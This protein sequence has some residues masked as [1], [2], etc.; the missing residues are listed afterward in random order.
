[1][2]LRIGSHRV[3][4]WFESACLVVGEAGET[5][6]CATGRSTL[7]RVQDVDAFCARAVEHGARLI[8]ARSTHV[9]GERQATLADFA[10]HTWTLTK[11]VDAI[12]P[13]VWGGEAVEL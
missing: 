13:A 1:M 2:R 12:D 3:Q 9:Y 5:N 10:G 7:L 11:T 4:L 8:D 6:Q